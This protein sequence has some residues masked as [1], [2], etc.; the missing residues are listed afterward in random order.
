MDLADESEMDQTFVQSLTHELMNIQKEIN[1]Y[2][3]R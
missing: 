3:G 2:G 1:K